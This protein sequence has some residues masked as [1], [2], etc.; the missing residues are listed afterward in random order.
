MTLLDEE[1]E[2]W[3]EMTETERN[4]IRAMLRDLGLDETDDADEYE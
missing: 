1:I 3:D 4:R 2:G